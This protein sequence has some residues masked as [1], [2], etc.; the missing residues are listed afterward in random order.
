MT[1]YGVSRCKS[2]G[3]EI[4][5]IKTTGGRNM[6]CDAGGILYREDPK[7]ELTIVTRDGKTVK[8]T[9][10]D[11]SSLIGYTSHFANLPKRE[12]MAEGPAMKGER[13]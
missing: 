11:R 6:P 2:C 13:T 1:K 5:W 12:R 9:R 10:D 3:K 7:G 4:I 8:A